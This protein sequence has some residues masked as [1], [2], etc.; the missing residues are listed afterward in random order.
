MISL[1]KSF[2]NFFFKSVP[3]CTMALSKAWALYSTYTYLNLPYTMH[4]DLNAQQTVFQII[5]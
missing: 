2:D 1:Q 3:V 4:G 5:Y